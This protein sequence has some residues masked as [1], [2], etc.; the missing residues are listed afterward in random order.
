MTI[1]YAITI[2]REMQRWRRGEGP[3]DKD[4][5][6]TMPYSPKEFGEAIDVAIERMEN[7]IKS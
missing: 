3:Y 5:P 7:E 2:L 6:T 4:E 1:R